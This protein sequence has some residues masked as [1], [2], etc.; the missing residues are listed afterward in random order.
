MHLNHTSRWRGALL[1]GTTAL[2]LLA[3][4]LAI[5][6]ST[7]NA[8]TYDLSALPD[9][10]MTPFASIDV[11]TGDVINI[12]GTSSDPQCE[13]V[14]L[15][16]WNNL[17][18][19]EQFPNGG[20]PLYRVTITQPGSAGVDFGNGRE[21][22]I[23][24]SPGV[25]GAPTIDDVVPGNGEATVHFSPPENDGG[26]TITSYTVT[27]EPGGTTANGSSSPITIAGLENGST[28]TLT[29]AATNVA[30][31][32]PA[33]APWEVTLLP[34]AGVSLAITPSPSEY[35]QTVQ[36]VATIVGNIP[37]GSV[38]FEMNG[39]TIGSATVGAEGVAALDVG[40]LE[41]GS[42]TFRATYS[43]DAGHQPGASN[44]VL[45]QV[46]KASS[47][48]VLS[49]NFNHVLAGETVI[50]TAQVQAIPGATGTVMFRVNGEI[51]GTSD[52]EQGV[53]TLSTNRFVV[54]PNEVT[55]EYSGSEFVFGSVAESISVFVHEP[56]TETPSA[57]PT[58]TSTPTT[59]T[60]EPTE[61]TTTPTATPSTPTPSAKR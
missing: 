12:T 18:T 31:T 7:A 32:G 30:G 22:T 14:D 29:V 55:A 48:T 21:L 36:L 28:Y 24:A 16:P 41:L 8:E 34:V 38:D 44:A 40:P 6:R 9:I 50:V 54:G 26:S 5:P 19:V 52:L 27:A 60:P 10:C 56:G 49:A 35:G 47:T 37:T 11:A 43:G 53:A 15:T 23:N 17:W 2:V 25:P 1:A 39:E 46:T 42:Y 45:H 20:D 57:T 13:P 58:P 59:T 33:S 51:A 61:T 3:T 4:I